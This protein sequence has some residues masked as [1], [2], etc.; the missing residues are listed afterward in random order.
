MKKIAA[1]LLLMVGACAAVW[2]HAAAQKASTD[3]VIAKSLAAVGSAEDRAKVKNIAAAGEV[4]FSKTNPKT[5]LNPG[6]FVTS[7]EGDKFLLAMSFPSSVYQMEKIVFNGKDSSV[8]NSQ[9]GLRSL[10]GDYLYRYDVIVKHGLLGGVLSQNWPLYK[11]A[12]SNAKISLDGS[13]K[14]D[15]KDCYVLRYEPK[16]GSDLTIKIYIE[17][18][19]GHHLRTEYR[20]LL[21]GGAGTNP[22]TSSRITETHEDM[23]EDFGDFKTEGGLNLPHSYKI[24]LVAERQ[25]TTYLGFW[26]VNLNDFYFNSQLDAATFK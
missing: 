6:K 24:S 16:K 7:S 22:N 8:G 20:R 4:G 14:I 1:L 23:T 26:L 17:K 12:L 10:F 13:K 2:Q 15:G 9:P 21:S 18:E 3:E 19:T 11:S 25:T 5:I